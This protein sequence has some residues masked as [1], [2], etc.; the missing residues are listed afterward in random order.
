[1]NQYSHDNFP[2]LLPS[3]AVSCR[4]IGQIAEQAIPD[5]LTFTQRSA[6]HRASFGK[7]SM[8]REHAL[9]RSGAP[10]ITQIPSINYGGL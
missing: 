10:A 1:M 3:V 4:F 6:S 7:T 2:S 5:F 8:L 9:A